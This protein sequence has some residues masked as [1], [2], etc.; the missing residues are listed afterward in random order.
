MK[1]LVDDL[2]EEKISCNL[3]KLRLEKPRAIAFADGSSVEVLRR[4]PKVEPDAV[5]A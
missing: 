4:V 5:T 3:I 2:L 1:Q